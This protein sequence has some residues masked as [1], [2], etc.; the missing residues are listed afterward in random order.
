MY[1]D[2]KASYLLMPLAA[3][4]DGASLL[5]GDAEEG[6]KFDFDDSDDG[7]PEMISQLAG[8]ANRQQPGSGVQ[9]T[10]KPDVNGAT[11]CRL[12][13]KHSLYHLCSNKAGEERCY[14]KC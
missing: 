8:D 9:E 13:A 14:A 11:G 5:E 4:P 2:T 12:T 10:T 3:A 6:E 1:F 7:G